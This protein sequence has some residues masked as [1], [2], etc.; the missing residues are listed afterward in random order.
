[1][2]FTGLISYYTYFLAVQRCD[3]NDTHTIHGLWIDYTKGSYPEYCNKSDKFNLNELIEIKSE[4]DKKWNSCYGNTEKLW[5][6][7][8]LKHGTCFYPKMSL[9]YY[10]TKT[11]KLFDIKNELIKT[12]QKKECL[13]PIDFIEL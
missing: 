7:E 3:K 1:M 4:L 2:K 11:L 5:K 13:I 6:H 12:C 8:W 10:F 9:K